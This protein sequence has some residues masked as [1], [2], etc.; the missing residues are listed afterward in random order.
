MRRMKNLLTLSSLL[1]FI[2]SCE[3]TGGLSRDEKV[4]MEK[5]MIAISDSLFNAKFTAV[6]SSKLDSLMKED[7]TN[8]TPPKNLSPKEIFNQFKNAIDKNDLSEA[9]KYIHSEGIYFFGSRRI[10]KSDFIKDI[11]KKASTILIDGEISIEDN[12]SNAAGWDGN[13]YSPHLDFDDWME[14]DGFFV[15]GSK[16]IIIDPNPEINEECLLLELYPDNNEWRVYAVGMW[17]WSP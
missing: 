5:K 9:Q 12:Y 7:E 16:I 1:L 15:K 17:Y 3:N 10:E 2:F 6:N 11:G 4:W 14:R 8:S 13:F